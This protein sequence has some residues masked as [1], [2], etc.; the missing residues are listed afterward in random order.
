MPVVDEACAP[1]KVVI[2]VLAPI[3]RR[4]NEQQFMLSLFPPLCFSLPIQVSASHA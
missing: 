2:E 3:R 1:A 4:R